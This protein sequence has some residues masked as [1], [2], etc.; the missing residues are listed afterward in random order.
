MSLSHFCF[1]CWL[2]VA[3][4]S[5]S[6]LR[7]SQRE[8]ESKRRKEW[9]G[10]RYLQVRP[11]AEPLA[12]AAAWQCTFLREREGER[13][14]HPAAAACPLLL[15]DLAKLSLSFPKKLGKSFG[16]SCRRNSTDWAAAESRI[17]TPDCIGENK[18]SVFV[19]VGREQILRRSGDRSRAPRPV[20]SRS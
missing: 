1:T 15:S 8:Q 18:K 2:A 20:E 14:R 3:F 4:F 6:S 19:V 9:G 11:R 5:V 12:V 10:T 13:G 17:A 16:L 7:V